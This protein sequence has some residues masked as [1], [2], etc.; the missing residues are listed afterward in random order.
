V[1]YDVGHEH[2]RGSE[3]RPVIAG[4]ARCSGV[5]EAAVFRTQSVGSPYGRANPEGDLMPW[6]VRKS[7]S[8]WAIVNRHGKVVGKSG[9][10]AKAQA[11]VRARYANYKPGRKR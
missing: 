7:G 5:G 11:S 4:G 9:S 2:S 6:K 10:K 8:K 1:W 3:T